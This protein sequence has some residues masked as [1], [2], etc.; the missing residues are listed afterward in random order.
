MGTTYD[1]VAYSS[2]AT[3]SPAQ[4]LELARLW[5]SLTPSQLDRWDDAT[6]QENT[7]EGHAPCR[8]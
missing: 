5:N 8:N 3:L 1:E 2:N 7:R 4:V 6:R